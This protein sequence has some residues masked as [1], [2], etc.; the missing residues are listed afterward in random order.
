MPLERSLRR[1]P[2][3]SWKW[4]RSFKCSVLVAAWAIHLIPSRKWV[5]SSSII[6]VLPISN[7]ILLPSKARGSG[8]CAK[9]RHCSTLNERIWP[10]IQNWKMFHSKG[11]NL[12]RGNLYLSHC[13]S[14][15]IIHSVKCSAAR[16]SIASWQTANITY[17]TYPTLISSNGCMATA[18][19]SSCSVECV[20]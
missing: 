10:G 19:L 11:S 12:S 8:Q 15:I 3:D 14:L 2:P 1:V 7:L 20:T 13:S 6:P 9:P 17:V 16:S 5:D 18:C 4:K